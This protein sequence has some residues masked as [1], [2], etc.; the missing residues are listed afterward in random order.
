MLSSGIIDDYWRAKRSLKRYDPGSDGYKTLKLKLWTASETAQRQSQLNLSFILDTARNQQ[1]THAIINEK[2]I[3]LIN[4][5]GDI[6]SI[7]TDQWAEQTRDHRPDQTYWFTDHTRYCYTWAG[8]P[9]Q[10]SGFYYYSPLIVTDTER[11]FYDVRT[12]TRIRN[13]N[14][15][16]EI[17]CDAGF[18]ARRGWPY[19]VANPQH[20]SRLKEARELSWATFIFDRQTD[21]GRRIRG[22]YNSLDR[23]CRWIGTR[24]S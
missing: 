21:V 23:S 15:Q 20:Y 5:R 11:G 7:I 6:R 9:G 3:Q 14:E 18:I 19:T 8:D 2:T 17:I 4:G 16:L 13:R 1:C 22:I 10:C 12:Q 24:R